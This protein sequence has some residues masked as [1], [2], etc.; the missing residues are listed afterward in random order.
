M[1]TEHLDEMVK[2]KAN[3]DLELAQLRRFSEPTP[4]ILTINSTARG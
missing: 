1:E 3:V 4:R 2:P